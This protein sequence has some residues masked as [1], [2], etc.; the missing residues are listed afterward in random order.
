MK[1]FEV[2]Y[3]AA[4]VLIG[5]FALVGCGGVTITDGD[6]MVVDQT[7]KAADAAL[8]QLDLLAVIFGEEA[9]API[10]KILTDIKANTVYAVELVGHPKKPK[11]YT[12]DNAAAARKQ[13]V[14]EHASSSKWAAF[15]TGIGG[16][17]L[18]VGRKLLSAYVPWLALPS[19]K[20]A[21]AN[22]EGVAK[23]REV[24]VTMTDAL[25]NK[26]EAIPVSVLDGFLK[27]AQENAGVRDF[28]RKLVKKTE[29]K[30]G[31]DPDKV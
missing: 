26:V 11:P 16:L 1:R 14:D 24:S 30:L 13:A 28:A 2:K 12:Q 19:E 17:A 9:V 20:S 6:Q 31:L 8:H 18:V 27:T 25:N 3:W 21:V 15:W 4:A 23:A 29:D 10:R 22:V 7:D 5:I